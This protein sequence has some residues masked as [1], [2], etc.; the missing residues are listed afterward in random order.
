MPYTLRHRFAG[1]AAAAS[2]QALLLGG[3]AHA[4]TQPVRIFE[5]PP[6]LDLLRSIMVP[7]SKP[8][9]TRRIVI[10]NPERPAPL[11]TPAAMVQPEIIAEPAPVAPARQPRWQRQQ[12]A[13]E[14]DPGPALASA[15]IASPPPAPAPVPAAAPAPAEPAAEAGIV[16]FRINFALDSDVVPRSATVSAATDAVVFEIAR[17]DLDPILRRRPEL[18]EGLAAIMASRQERNAG[19]G[20]ESGGPEAAE[21]AGREDLLGRL[22]A[23]FRL[24]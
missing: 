7:E 9:L 21:P 11:A 19:R 17:E 15:R 22:R 12:P 24:G 13:G 5:A 23:F 10:T 6:S 20:Q 1:L 14:P 2:L 3:S 8:G 18:A 16:G 4:Q